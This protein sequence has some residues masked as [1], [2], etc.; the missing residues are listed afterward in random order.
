[1]TI[2]STQYHQKR[3]GFSPE[4]KSQTSSNDIEPAFRFE[5]QRLM[6]EKYQALNV[7]HFDN[8]LLIV[9]LSFC[10][11]FTASDE[12]EYVPKKWQQY[13]LGDAEQKREQT[14]RWSP[15]RTQK[16][17]LTLFCTFDPAPFLPQKCKKGKRRQKGDVQNPRPRFPVVKKGKKKDKIKLKSEK[18]SDFDLTYCPFLSIGPLARTEI[19][20][21]V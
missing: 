16:A 13:P 9:L 5:K 1:M 21:K 18:K 19:V 3:G 4:A 17:A 20:S 15:A 10:L 2:F 12:V 14:K 11:L 6:L 8:W 7:Q